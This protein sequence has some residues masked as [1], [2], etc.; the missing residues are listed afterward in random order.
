MSITICKP[1]EYPDLVDIFIEMEHY[2]NR[3]AP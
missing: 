2:Y 1:H 3:L